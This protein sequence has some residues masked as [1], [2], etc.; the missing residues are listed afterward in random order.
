[1]GPQSFHL[2]LTHPALLA[3]LAALPLVAYYFYRSLVDFPR[4][5]RALSLACRS[6]IIVLL[7]LSV[8]GLT[9]FK[10]TREQFVVFAV[11]K[12]LSVGDDSRKTAQEF[13]QL[14]AAASGNNRIAYLGFAAEPGLVHTEQAKE[15]PQLDANGTNIA[16]AI[17]AAAAAIPPSYVPHIV[18]V[19]DGNQ[20]AGDAL[21]A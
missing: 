3:G 2:E 21:K 10:P 8:A 15:S 9:A 7:V 11:D 4:A 20:T 16:A 17:E 14:A 5:Q 6:L 19:S 12:S 1:M 13:L 18:V